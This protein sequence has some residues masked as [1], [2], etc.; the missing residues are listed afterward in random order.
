MSLG[1]TGGLLPNYVVQ[2]VHQ[3]Y[4]GSTSGLLPNYVVQDVHQMSLGLTSGSLP[5]QLFRMSTR[6]LY[7]LPLVYHLMCC[8]GCPPGV[9]RVSCQISEHGKPTVDSKHQ[10]TRK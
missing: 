5:N 10:Y 3:V 6:C 9:S 1:S 2:G 8:S 7:G 4:L